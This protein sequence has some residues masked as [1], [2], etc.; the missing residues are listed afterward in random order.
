MKPF[1]KR[2]KIRELFAVVGLEVDVPY[3]H[4]ED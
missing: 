1:I 2:A 4:W 3:K